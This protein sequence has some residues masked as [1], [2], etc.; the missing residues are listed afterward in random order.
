MWLRLATNS[1]T[2]LSQFPKSLSCRSTPPYLATL[3]LLGE[4]HTV[5]TSSRN[6][7]PCKLTC[8]P[9]TLV[10]IVFPNSFSEKLFTNSPSRSPWT[11][12]DSS[13]SA[14]TFPAF[15]LSWTFYVSKN[16][17]SWF[18]RCVTSAI[19]LETSFAAEPCPDLVSCFSSNPE[20]ILIQRPI[21]RSD[22]HLC[23]PSVP[24]NCNNVLFSCLL[25][26]NIHALSHSWSLI[27]NRH[28]HGY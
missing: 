7:P 1:L 17:P 19:Q 6:P 28:S 26:A 5:I 15:C 11:V 22:T 20:K 4:T 2:L 8:W 14:A 25:P 16:L 12:F 3:N 10:W 23:L 24:G 18:K 21:L 27:K 13:A 9:Y